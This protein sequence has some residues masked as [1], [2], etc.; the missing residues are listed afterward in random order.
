MNILLVDN[1]TI[2]LNNLKELL[3]KND[4]KVTSVPIDKLKAEMADSYDAVVLSG[5]SKYEVSDS[6]E[7]F[8]EQFKIIKSG[9]PV[10]GVCLGF[11]AICYA[12]GEKV[13]HLGYEIEG[14]F[15]VEANKT[16]KLLEGLNK[17]FK[18]WEGHSWAVKKINGELITLAKS[19][20]CVEIVKHPTLPVY[21]SQFHPEVQELDGRKV[22]EN[23]IKMY[24]R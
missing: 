22:L 19:Q 6:P 20:K 8:K 2:F 13:G 9:K 11:Q 21:A 1:A 5:G 4:C 18:V 14:V 16:D 17:T 10:Y 3:N 24:S 15:D 23:F 7:M 12:F